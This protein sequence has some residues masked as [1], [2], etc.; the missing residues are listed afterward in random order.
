M[1]LAPSAAWADVDCSKVITVPMVVA[2]CGANAPAVAALGP[3][4]VWRDEEREGFDGVLCQRIVGWRASQVFLS[5]RRLPSPADAEEYV[6]GQVDNVA[7]QAYLSASSGFSPPESLVEDG[8]RYR[9]WRRAGTGGTV[10][11]AAADLA[12]EVT[13]RRRRGRD[14]QTPP[15]ICS[16]DRLRAL[17]AQVGSRLR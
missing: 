15:P 11:F 14:G 4:R 7:R 10:V 12:V 1:M 17:A 13:S 9:S 3:L 8:V 6:G 16:L 5:V 2:A